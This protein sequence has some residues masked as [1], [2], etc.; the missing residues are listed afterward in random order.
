MVNKNVLL[1]RIEKA[2]EY[3]SFLKKIKNEYTKVEFKN[4]PKIYGSSERF[5]HLTIEALLDIGNHIIADENLGKVEFY[6]DIPKILHN[7][8]YID[9]ESRDVFIKIIGFRNILVHDYVDIDLDIVFKVIDTN[10]VDIE[11]IIKQFAKLL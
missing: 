10:L 6:S 4:D 9:A 11:K 2:K 5:L 8:R 1:K 7:N 3:I